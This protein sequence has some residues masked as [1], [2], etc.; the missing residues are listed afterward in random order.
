GITIEFTTWSSLIQSNASGDNLGPR[1]AFRTN[2]NTGGATEQR[3]LSNVCQR[4]CEGALDQQFCV[5][6]IQRKIGRKHLVQ[7]LQ[8]VKEAVQLGVPV[9]AAICAPDVFTLSHPCGPCHEISHVRQYLNGRASIGS[10]RE[11]GE[12]WRDIPQNLCGA[13]SQS[14]DNMTQQCASSI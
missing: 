7:G 9:S 2:G 6:Q 5:A 14:S 8:A 4:I 3:D 11:F 10:A 13:I 12:F 1:I